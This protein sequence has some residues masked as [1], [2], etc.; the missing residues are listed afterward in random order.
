MNQEHCIF[1]V[2]SQYSRKDIYQILSVPKEKQRGNWETGYTKYNGEYYVFVNVEIPGRTGHNYNDRWESDGSLLWHG[3]KG[4]HLG[5]P[6]IKEMIEETMHC[7]FFTRSVNTNVYFTYQGIG[8]VI[9]YFD[10]EPVEIKWSFPVV[11]EDSF[12]RDTMP[13]FHIAPK[14]NERIS[15]TARNACIARYGCSCY[16]C[17]FNFEEHYGTIGEG[18]IRVSYY[19]KRDNKPFDPI[20]DLRPICPNCLAMLQRRPCLGMTMDSLKT[21]LK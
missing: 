5:Q 8:R 7:H 18:Y 10:R 11:Q 20:K 2:G 13:T 15:A 19:G 14:V 4:S 21:E 1:E 9:T 17:G 3:K 6:S 16:I 12:A